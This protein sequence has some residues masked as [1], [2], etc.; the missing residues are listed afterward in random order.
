MNVNSCSISEHYKKLEAEHA[1]FH[2]KKLAINEVEKE[3]KKAKKRL[4]GRLLI[5]E[6]CNDWQSVHHHG[7]LLQANLFRLTKG[8]KEIVIEDWEHD[9]IEKI[10]A[11]DP[12]MSPRDQVAGYFRR[13]KKL[14]AG[15][16]HAERLIK[17][18]EK[19]LAL[20]TEQRAILEAVCDLK[21]LENYFKVYGVKKKA[22]PPLSLKKKVEPAKPYQEYVSQSG[23]KIWVGKS[24]KDNDKLTF[25]YAKGSDFWMHAKNYP[26]SHVVIR[27]KKDQEI[28]HETLQ[29]AGELALRFSK[30]KG[31][32]DGEV[33][34]TQVK[35]LSRVKGV[36]GKV[37]LSKH[38]V[39]HIILDHERW[40]RLKL[41][42]PPK[43]SSKLDLKSG[44]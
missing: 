4:E 33:C 6:K 14:K 40:Q 5:L 20:V 1:F 2:Q 24:A 31:N 18:A 12:L 10:I 39:L 44:I 36:P 8:M 3:I 32:A 7:L 41:N 13:S 29:D 28:D 21:T 37:V 30:A 27:S 43:F 25:H 9:G 15:I 11:L 19:D 16:V 17:N 34:L 23:I 35:G 22:S 38:K 26:G 42:L